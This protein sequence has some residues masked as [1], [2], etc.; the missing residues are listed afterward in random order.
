[1]LRLLPALLVFVAFIVAVSSAGLREGLWSISYLTNWI[2]IAGYDPGPM[3]GHTW[4]LA[5]EE[6]FYLFFPL[7]M[8]LL[9]RRRAVLMA[10]LFLGALA[11]MAVRTWIDLGY[12]GN[13]VYRGTDLRADALLLG[14]VLGVAFVIW[15]APRTQTL[16]WC[17]PVGLGGILFV[18]ANGNHVFHYRAGLALAAIFGAVLVAGAVSDAPPSLLTWKPLVSIGKHAYGLYLWHGP[19]REWCIAVIDFEPLE[20]PAAFALTWVVAVASMRLVEQPFLRLKHRFAAHPDLDR[21]EQSGPILTAL[22]VAT[23]TQMPQVRGGDSTA[24]HSQAHFP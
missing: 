12:D 24:V 6:Q 16:R 13:R 2:W 11:P 4:T 20:M 1:M 23:S 18:G 9:F 8:T 17:V 22:P 5:V 14:C 19:V 10:T 3:L 21:G 15:G 7:W